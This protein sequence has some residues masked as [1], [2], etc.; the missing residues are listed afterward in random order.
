MGAGLQGGARRGRPRTL[1]GVVALPFKGRQ[2]GAQFLLKLLADT[3]VIPEDGRGLLIAPDLVAALDLAA[4]SHR[5][6]ITVAGLDAR[7]PQHRLG[8]VQ[9]A[10][11]LAA[12]R[13][14]DALARL[15]HREQVARHHAAR[16]VEVDQVFTAHRH[17]HH[18]GERLE[19]FFDLLFPLCQGR[20]RR[21]QQQDHPHQPTN[22]A[23]IFHKKNP[24]ETEWFMQGSHY[25]RKS[26]MTLSIDN[27]TG[28]NIERFRNG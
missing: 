21:Q 10:Q 7:H 1:G 2:R 19:I 11:H 26:F 16:S 14:H 8:L 28:I 22:M 6:R 24:P 12:D 20:T 23:H 15:H 18:A 25:S 13:V 5:H 9:G 4:L 3:F 27:Q 17:D